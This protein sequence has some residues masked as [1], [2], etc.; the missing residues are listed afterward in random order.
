[1]NSPPVNIILNNALCTSLFIRPGLTKNSFLN[2]KYHAKFVVTTFN[3]L[4]LLT[5]GLN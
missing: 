2:A 4:F 5:N 3:L 1:M